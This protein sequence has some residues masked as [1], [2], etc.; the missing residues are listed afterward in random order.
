MGKVLEN[1]EPKKVLHFFEEISKIPHGSYNEKQISDYLVNFAK[2]RNLSYVQDSAL[3]IVIYKDATNTMKDKPSVILQGHMDMVCEKNEG[4]KHDFEKDPLKLEVNGDFVSA[5][6]TTLGADNGIAVSMALAILDSNDVEHPS[7]E[8]LFTVEEEVG[9]RGAKVIDA[10]NFKSNLMINLDTDTEGYFLTSCAGGLKAEFVIPTNKTILNE[11]HEAF[12]I[13]ILGLKGGHS[14]AEIHKQRGNSNVILGRILNELKMELNIC[15]SLIKGGSKDNAIPREA[16]AVVHVLNEDVSM[17]KEKL[18]NISKNIK[19]EFRTSDEGLKIELLSK[20]ST[21][22]V[23]EEE[24]FNKIVSAITLIPNGIDSM[25]MEVEGLVET[26]NNVGVVINNEN[27]IN[28][29]CALRSSVATKKYDLLNRI[30]LLA[31]NLGCECIANED[32]PAWEYNPKSHL[33]DVYAKTYKEVFGVDAKIDA[34]HAGLECGILSEKMPN[35]DIVAFGPN[36]I[37]AHTPDERVSISS[38]EKCYKLLIS[39][40]KNL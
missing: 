23:Y 13:K 39:G 37:D 10:N 5:I 12:E 14:G 4:T 15:L 21:N 7:L 8:C 32:Y 33:R 11:P 26:S 22:E 30:K 3:N 6:G 19:N 27:N 35:V 38:I 31:K 24:T 36:I 17:F 2:E 25:S 1:Y 20:N 34:I 40:F 29:L 28:I 18:Q 9:L 16:Q